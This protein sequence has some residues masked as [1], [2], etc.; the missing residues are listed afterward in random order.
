LGQFGGS[1][2]H[3]YITQASTFRRR[4]AGVHRFGRHRFRLL[5]HE[6]AHRC[7]RIVCDKRADRY[8]H[9]VEQSGANVP[10]RHGY[11]QRNWNG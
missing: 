10:V 11:S 5:E 6:R 1:Q 7:S 4:I 8:A 9:Y 2:L 3:E